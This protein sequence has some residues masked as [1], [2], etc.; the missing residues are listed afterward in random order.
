MLCWWSRWAVLLYLSQPRVVTQ[1]NALDAG[2]HGTVPWILKL[3]QVSGRNDW[4]PGLP[5]AL[6]GRRKI[7]GFSVPA[8]QNGLEHRIL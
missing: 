4:L 7:G 1:G 5:V 8:P 2:R 3:A 6:P